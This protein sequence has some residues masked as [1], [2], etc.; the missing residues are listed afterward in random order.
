MQIGVYGSGYLGTVIS[1]CLADFGTPVSCCHPDRTRMVEMAQGNI[2]FFEKNLKEIIRRNVRAGRLSY[3][4]D[5]ETF[6]RRTGVI[7]LAEDNADNLSDIALRII[8]LAPKPPILT[9][10]T[11]VSVGTANALEKTISDAGLQATIVSQPMFFTDGCA[12]E[13][14][15]WP[16]RLI[17]GSASN[18]AVQ[19]LKQIFHPLVMRG[20][21]VIVTNQATAELVREAATAFVAT[22]ISF[23]NEVANLCDRIGCDVHDVARAMGMDGRIGRKFLHPGPGFG[24]SCFP[25]DT[26]ALVSVARE[27]GTD[28]LIVEAVIEVNERQ[29]AAMIPKIEKLTGNLKGKTIAVLGLS[30]KPETNDMRDAPSVDIIR[31]L[32]ERGAIIR[33][34]DPVAMKE[35]IKV[36][37]DIMYVEDEYTAVEGADVLVFMTEW[38]QFRALDMQRIHTLMRAP[39]I[40][41]LRN[42]YE[43]D[44]MRELGF[45]YTG[46]GR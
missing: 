7:F 43:P 35:A 21:P 46:V 25:K 45:D 16:D 28:S 41:D 23:I 11:P 26:R 24:G 3:S 27:Y 37:P 6:A 17:L 33:A 38:N 14:F 29:R 31:G 15:N 8:R 40:A 22:K 39:R 42:I 13:D 19:V 2:P 9:I 10:V 1:A 18:E 5:I 12:V 36:L 20:V 30:F 44:D 4:T 32:T 34:Y